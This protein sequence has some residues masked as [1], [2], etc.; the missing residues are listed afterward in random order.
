MTL[1]DRITVLTAA[2]VATGVAL[3]AVIVFVAEYG[4]SMDA[5]DAL[6]REKAANVSGSAVELVSADVEE[7]DVGHARVVRADGTSSPV[8]M[9]GL[10]AAVEPQAREVAAGQQ[11]RFTANLQVGEETYRVLTVPLGDGDALQVAEPLG[12]V[13]RQLLNLAGVLALATV[14]GLSVAVLL[15][16]F[17][18][19]RALQPVQRLSDGAQEIAQ[20]R[21]LSTRVDVRGSDELGR[22]GE[23]FNAMLE[24]LEQAHRS[25]R[26]LVSD[27][28][29]EL[30]TP[31]SS[32][33]ANVEVLDEA[34]DLDRHD[35]RLLVRD[36]RS[37]V[38]D[39]VT[40][41]DGLLSLARTDETQV[42]REE[43]ALDDVVSDAIAWV[44]RRYPQVR[45]RSELEP[46]VL[47]GDQALVRSA[48]GNVLDNAAKWSS[49]G[50]TVEV[51]LRA[52]TLTVRDHGPGIDEADLPHVFER[53]YRSRAARA[54]PGAGLG[55]AIVHEVADLHGWHASA[56]RAPGGG[57]LVR[58]DLQSDDGSRDVSSGAPDSARTTWW[59][60][61][62]A[63]AG[64]TL[65]PHARTSLAVT[66]GAAVPLG[67]AVG[68][69][70][71]LAPSEPPTL[72]TV[73][74]TLERCGERVCIDG[75]V[76]DFGPAWYVR[77]AEAGHDYDGD[78]DAGSLADEVTGLLGREVTLETDGG[79]LDEDVFTV[80][81][82]PLRS[83][84]GELPAPT[85]RDPD[86][87]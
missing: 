31:L 83:P 54:M 63:A 62:L 84:D 2:A 16:R 43:I 35:R 80:N 26:R 29:H 58:L 71:L 79:S 52:D 77:E 87:S 37:E 76:M 15:G 33:Q 36:L 65:R 5:V 34:D 68:A 70:L 19:A 61:P 46:V 41:V 27:A 25:Q 22:L 78:G 39:L 73:M 86:R 28:S 75:S 55:L 48:V 82:M 3:V 47:H 67:V 23:S 59:S 51:C 38:G 72:R 20:T 85:G 13:R 12:E 21:D 8:G 53:F 11:D 17:V 49:A 7:W 32:V 57:C 44:A 4:E 74:G 10:D 9:A 66:A 42:A 81:G 64:A 18:A 14:G 40:T 6:L 30:L 60:R 24:E 1:R 69:L 56:L 45:F 50:G